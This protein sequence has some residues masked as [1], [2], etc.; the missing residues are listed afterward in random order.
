[1]RYQYGQPLRTVRDAV[2]KCYFSGGRSIER[3]DIVA[4]RD[5]GR[6][7][8]YEENGLDAVFGIAVDLPA[9]SGKV[10]VIKIARKRKKEK[11]QFKWLRELRF[12]ITQRW[13]V[14]GVAIKQGDYLR[15]AGESVVPVMSE[16]I[17]F[18]EFVG[19][20]QHDCDEGDTCNVATPCVLRKEDGCH[21]GGVRVRRRYQPTSGG[22]D[23]KAS[24][25][26]R[27]SPL[28]LQ[29]RGGARR[30]QGERDDDTCSQCGA[31]LRDAE[32]T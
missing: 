8:V 2:I 26:S 21:S 16:I 19:F 12:G 7:Y 25:R 17:P 6:I 1:M 23:A 32:R 24:R 30:R 29:W 27:L 13:Y 28:R 3:G 15:L 22:C 31:P 18:D 10:D 5:D 14:A 4:R 20:A 9:E 11:L